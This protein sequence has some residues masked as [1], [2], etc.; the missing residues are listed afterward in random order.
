[1]H[2]SAHTAPATATA[3]G[4]VAAWGAGLV[5]IALGAGALTSEGAARGAGFVLVALG[6]G[7]LAWGAVS[8]VRGRTVAPRAGVGG[9]LAGIV[10]TAALLWLDPARTSA[11]TVAAASVLLVV[12]ALA[13]GVRLRRKTATDAA[14]PRLPALI[15][16]AVVVAAIATPALGSTE[17]ART[18]PAHG[19]HVAPTE[20]GHHRP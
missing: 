16:A 1:M 13:C 9:A 7:A 14:P 3:A 6:A 5:Q 11:A 20:P 15:A 19:G 12:A 17:A 8:L 10:A 18:S 2:A 4:A